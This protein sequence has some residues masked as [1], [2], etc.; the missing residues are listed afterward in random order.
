MVNGFFRVFSGRRLLGSIVTEADEKFG[1]DES[2]IVQQGAQNA[3]NTLDAFVV[4]VGA[5]IEIGHVLIIGA[6]VDFTIFV[7]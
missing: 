7:R 1:V 5:V 4:K 6:I 2:G 3:L